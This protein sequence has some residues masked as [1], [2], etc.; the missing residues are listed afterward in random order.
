MELVE[1]GQLL[2]GRR[3]GDWAPDHL[4]HAQSRATAGVAVELRHDHAID[5]EGLVE[6]FSSR[7]GVLA[8]HRVDHEER[9]VGLHRFAD[10]ANLVHEF[11]VDGQT[12][13]G[14]D[15]Q[16]V[17]AESAGFFETISRNTDRVRVFAEDRHSD[18]ARQHPKLLNRSRAL[19]VGSDD[20]HVAPL[21]LEPAGQFAGCR[22]LAGTLQTG[23]E[24]D[25][26]RLRR[27]FDLEGLTAERLDQLVVDDLDHLL[28]RVQDRGQLGAH[29]R[30]ADPLDQVAYDDEVDVGL[31]QGHPNLAQD[32]VDFHLTESATRLQA[33]EDCIETI[34]K[35]VKHRP[36]AYAGPVEDPTT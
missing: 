33:G 9:V 35:A 22:G 8:G 23:H 15:N 10:A 12:A 30:D 28:G 6:R 4:F 14:V 2:P 3:E 7:Y 36:P 31:Q 27:E 29:A 21:G 17:F 19:K 11:D 18:L 5:R 32:L 24:D 25:G 1:V 13:G 20:Q 16:N 26:R 34:R